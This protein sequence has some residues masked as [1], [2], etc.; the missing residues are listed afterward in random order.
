M[1]LG[2]AIGLVWSR[3][4][5]RRK[6]REGKVTVW[7]IWA[8]QTTNFLAEFFWKGC[9]N[10]GNKLSLARARNH[11]RGS[12]RF[13]VHHCR[14]HF[15]LQDH[16]WS[17]W[18][19]EMV[20]L[21]GG[22]RG[23]RQAMK[24]FLGLVKQWWPPERNLRVPTQESTRFAGRCFSNN[25]VHSAFWLFLEYNPPGRGLKNHKPCTSRKLSVLCVHTPAV[26]WF[27]TVPRRALGAVANQDG[28]LRASILWPESRDV[29]LFIHQFVY[30]G[31]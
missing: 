30:C 22:A 15:L 27:K 10:T 24:R 12:Q 16:C 20:I 3:H 29:G 2:R 1:I 19:L 18:Q 31:P 25:A 11:T 26:L 23:A 5:T 9:R 6:R 7:T 13:Q 17:T 28:S 4:R 8:A 14:I 21:K